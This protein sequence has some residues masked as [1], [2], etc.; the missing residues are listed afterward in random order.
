MTNLPVRR[1]AGICAALLLLAVPALANDAIGIWRTEKGR[2]RVAECGG[3]LCGTVESI[4][5][6]NDPK[7]GKP[8]TDVLNPNET[9]RSRPIVGLAILTGMKA[10]G[11]GTWKGNIYN[12]E[13]GKTYAATMKLEGSTLKVSGCVASVLCRTQVWTR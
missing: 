7:T 8:Q 6:P 10:S 5:Q 13:D 12:P 4:H 11:D 1:A 3:S 2:V 9:L